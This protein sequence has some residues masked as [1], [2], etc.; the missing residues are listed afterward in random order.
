MTNE[1]GIPDPRAAPTI[2]A[3]DALEAMDVRTI[4]AEVVRKALVLAQRQAR[5]RKQRATAVA[6]IDDLLGKVAAAV[7]EERN[8]LVKRFEA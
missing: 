5:L 6:N 3:V 2:R 1:T 4:A 8:A 7:A